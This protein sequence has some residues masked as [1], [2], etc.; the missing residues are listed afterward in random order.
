MSVVQMS[1]RISSM[2][3]DCN[4]T[5]I[6][7]GVL[8]PAKAGAD[9]VLAIGFKVAT[10][11]GL[12]MHR[13]TFEGNSQPRVH[14]M[15]AFHAA[16]I[17]DRVHGNFPKP[18]K[19]RLAVACASNI[20]TA[21]PHPVIER[22]R[23]VSIGVWIGD[24]NTGSCTGIIHKFG[25]AQS[26]ECL[27]RVV[28]ERSTEALDGSDRNTSK[29]VERNEVTVDLVGLGRRDVGHGVV[30]D[31]VPGNIPVGNHGVIGVVE[32]SEVS[33]F[34]GAAVRISA[35]SQKL[36]YRVDSV[37]LDGVIAASLLDMWLK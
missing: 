8:H 23:P 15:R 36:V 1:T 19:L 5:V 3:Y 4:L 9:V 10:K 14:E 16:L 6:S 33:H 11:E 21:V 28:Q 30:A 32:G 34:G 13:L 25:V 26:L 37:G 24:R 17:E 12:V 22:V 7:K 29:R 35:L 2:G 27:K 20:S 18:G 31:L